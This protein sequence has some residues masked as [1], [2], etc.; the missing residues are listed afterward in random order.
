MVVITGLNQRHRGDD[1]VGLW[2]ETV[3]RHAIDANE[4][5][6]PGELIAASAFGSSRQ[7]TWAIASLCGLAPTD[8]SIST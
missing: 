6:A 7:Q 5:T 2:H 8:S 1:A 3:E 4:R